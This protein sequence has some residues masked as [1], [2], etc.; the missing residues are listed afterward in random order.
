MEKPKNTCFWAVPIQGV[1]DFGTGV[2]ILPALSLKV[3]PMLAGLQLVNR[4]KLDLCQGNSPF[5]LSY[6]Y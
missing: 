5:F 4:D 1:F 6:S 2:L 3:P